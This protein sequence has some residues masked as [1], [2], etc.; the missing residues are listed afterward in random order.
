MSLYQSLALNCKIMAR[1]LQI[2]IEIKGLSL[3]WRNC[4]NFCASLLMHF[5]LKLCVK[6]QQNHPYF[7]AVTVDYGVIKGL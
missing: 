6:K 1:I 7:S 5:A 4:F 3:F 2:C